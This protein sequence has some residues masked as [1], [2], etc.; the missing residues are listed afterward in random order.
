MR[1]RRLKTEKLP[2]TA[3]KILEITD[4]SGLSD[5]GAETGRL[6][7]ADG[8]RVLSEGALAS[9]LGYVQASAGQNAL[10]PG[11]YTLYDCYDS[12]YETPVNTDFIYRNIC[13]EAVMAYSET[14][15][16]ASRVLVGENLLPG[17]T[18]DGYRNLLGAYADDEAFYIF[19]DAVLNIIDHRR[20]DSF[21]SVGSGIVV[22]FE[23]LKSTTS[24]YAYT[25]HQLWL[26]VVTPGTGAVVSKMLGAERTQLFSVPA[27]RERAT[28]VSEDQ[29]TYRYVS[30]GYE[31]DLGG[32]YIARPDTVYTGDYATLGERNPEYAP[33]ADG[34]TVARYRRYLTSISGEQVGGR[35]YALV[36]P[37]MQILTVRGG[38][39]SVE[40]PKDSMPQMEQA[41]QHFGRLFGI[42][43]TEIY[44]SRNG[45]C[46]DFT[47]PAPGSTDASAAWTAT[48]AGTEGAFTAL[49]SFDGKIVAF[50]EKSMMTV[51]GGDLPFSLSYVGAHGCRSQ[52]ALAAWG[53]YLYFVSDA[54]VMQYNGTSVKPISSELLP[55]SLAGASLCAADGMLLLCLPLSETIYIYDLASGMWSS[56]REH[57][58]E[59]RLFG[60]GKMAAL[61]ARQ[62]LGWRLWLMDGG[63]AQYSF[64]LLLDF[65]Q[66][67][68]IDRI[69]LT[70]E[71]E[72]GASL[73]VSGAD[74]DAMFSAAGMDGQ[75]RAY[76]FAPRNLYMESGVLRFFG[77]GRVK[78]YTLRLEYAEVENT[79][80]RYGI[81]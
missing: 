54:G 49:A 73:S 64:S 25:V 81:C 42:Y 77:V 12:V 34:M 78:I 38:S 36:L 55:D 17:K 56:R 24:T 40:A 37:T 57:E 23:S 35:D 72:A 75:I 76:S 70:A 80:G 31:P 10:H 21:E 7:L 6:L 53:S 20:A 62:T 14:E 3:R 59:M 43:G 41:V 15:T 28:L 2:A 19:Y 39:I 45:D 9:I 11:V 44:A 18:A 22:Q 29:Q 16:V 67:R 33:Y 66:R 52:S 63:A 5:R 32:F 71:L 68:R 58:E 4:F 51:E 30:S 74:G 61:A 79:F 47:L 26:D 8:I 69:S 50:T 1:G 48:A 46:T 60:S 27:S 65:P 13:P